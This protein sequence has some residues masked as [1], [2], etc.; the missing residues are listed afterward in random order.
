MMAT[1]DLRDEWKDF[2]AL[3]PF[4]RKFMLLATALFP[5]TQYSLRILGFHKCKWIIERL[6]DPESC[7]NE[8]SI[9][10]GRNSARRISRATDI[11]ESHCRKT[12]T[13]LER[14]LVLWCLLGFGGI[15]SELRI[16]A[17]K[18]ASRFEAH[19]WVEFDGEV[20]NDGDGAYTQFYPFDSS[21]IGSSSGTERQFPE[22]T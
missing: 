13:C 5:V 16:G 12:P 18:A 17:R 1:K 6:A 11:A 3:Q 22:Q 21:I 4:E 7:C 10:T 15:S 9:T 19:A 8:S 2:W 14:S 20:L